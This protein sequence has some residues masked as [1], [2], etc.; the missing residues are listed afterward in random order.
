[1]ATISGMKIEINV[2]GA[3]PEDAADY[4]QLVATQLAEGYVEGHV[5]RDTNWALTGDRR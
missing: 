1:M 5:D 3:E 2:A 4:V